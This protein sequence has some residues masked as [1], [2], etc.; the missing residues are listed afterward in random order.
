MSNRPQTIFSDPERQPLRTEELFEVLRARILSD[1]WKAG[2]RLP[3]ERELAE[4]Y[5]T[6]RNTLREAL[7]RLEQAGLVT[8]R[9]GQGVTVSDF[10]RL[11]GLDLVAPFLELGSDVRE[12]AQIMLDVLEPRKRVLE[13]VVERFVQRFAASDLPPIEDAVRE[14]RAAEVARDPKALLAA[15]A[16]MFE[17]LVDGTHDQIVRWLSRPL[18]ELSRDVQRRWPSL[19]VFDPSLS[20]FASRLLEASVARD[21]ARAVSSLRAHYD[22]IDESLRAMLTPFIEVAASSSDKGSTP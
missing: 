1:E 11:G 16:K 17:A 4:R 2:T 15:E 12:K 14:M 20:R 18:L 5:D 19:V 22:A 6:N 8:V 9:H 13:Y 21:P 3:G 7:R 10:R